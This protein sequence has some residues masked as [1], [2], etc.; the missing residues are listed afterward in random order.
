MRDIRRVLIQMRKTNR[1]FSRSNSGNPR[2]HR[3]SLDETSRNIYIYISLG[4]IHGFYFTKS[5]TIRENCKEGKKGYIDE[6]TGI[7]L[8]YLVPGADHFILSISHSFDSY[9]NQTNGR[10]PHLQLYCQQ[11][12]TE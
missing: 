8:C 12:Q 9:P 6:T 11:H 4:E 2:S 7:S 3:S 1:F 10:T 5:G